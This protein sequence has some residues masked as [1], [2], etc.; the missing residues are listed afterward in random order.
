MSRKIEYG[1]FQTPQSVAARVCGLIAGIGLRPATVVEPTCG[2]SQASNPRDGIGRLLRLVFAQPG[3]EI[4][5]AV[6]SR[7]G[8]E[9]FLHGRLGKARNIK[10]ECG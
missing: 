1:D 4:Q 10:G 8:G 7:G 9:Q 5:F 6:A 2:T 3:P